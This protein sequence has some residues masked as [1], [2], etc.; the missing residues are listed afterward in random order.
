MSDFL[1]YGR[2]WIDDD[3]VAAVVS[4]LRGDWLT[5]GPTITEFERAL[6]TYTGARH[7]VAVANGTAALH[8]A[9]QALGIPPGAEGI[10]TPNT[11]VA[12]AN[13]LAYSGLRPVLA[14]IEETTYNLDLDQVARR[15]TAATRV[16]V[17]VH[18][19][20]QP[21]DM[22]ALAVLRRGRD[23]Q[24]VEDAAHAIGSRYAD[25]SRVGSCRHSDMTTFSFHPV[26][27]ITTG[28]GGAI[29][30]NSDELFQR[31]LRLRTHGITRDPALVQRHDG[32]WYYEMH[33]LG[34]NYRIT[35][36]QAALGLSQLGKLDRFMA[37]RREIVAQYN[38]AFA[39][40]AFVRTPV[41]RPGVVSCFHLYVLR[42][43]FARAKV[44]RGAMMERLR[45]RRIGTQ[46][47]YIPIHLQ[48][49]YARQYG[50]RRGDYPVA[51]RYYDEAIS[52]PL[53]P[54][55]TDADVGRVVEG[56]RSVLGC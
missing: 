1:S 9:V 44:A 38:A 48:P 10:T 31:L 24:T 4:V 42:I 49:Y 40:L 8:I 13:C 12:S 18:F 54:A 33:D 43:D 26:K 47:H 50:F 29:T 23:I 2:Q 32:P 25:G 41:E 11:F 22:D 19:A 16:L 46:V 56:V 30:T 51:E 34:Y 3:D 7:C 52:L 5:Q 55:M 36:L 20:G 14:D 27:T 39:G 28:E 53:F 21:L 45:E 37:R 17:P 6:A 35:D 15:M